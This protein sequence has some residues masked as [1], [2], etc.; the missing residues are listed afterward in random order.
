MEIIPPQARA[1]SNVTSSD[2]VEGGSC[3]V[4]EEGWVKTPQ[5]AL[6]TE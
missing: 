2:H 6:T 5:L 1:D 4:E 3:T